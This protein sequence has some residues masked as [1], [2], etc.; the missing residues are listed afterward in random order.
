MGKTMTKSGWHIIH[1][2]GG[3]P[4]WQELNELIRMDSGVQEPYCENEEDYEKAIKEGW[5]RFDGKETTVWCD[6]E[7]EAEPDKKYSYDQEYIKK[8]LKRILITFNRNNPG[9]MQLVRWI[10]NQNDSM[11]AYIKGLVEKD[12]LEARRRLNR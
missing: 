5:I 2:F 1:R 3:N 9:D 11:N 4:S 8:N 10:E 6:G 7:Y 12:M